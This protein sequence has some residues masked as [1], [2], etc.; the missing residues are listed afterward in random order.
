M[1]LEK[2]EKYAIKN[3]LGD[4]RSNW[5]SINDVA[6]AVNDV[7]GGEASAPKEPFQER[8]RS[9]D[10]NHARDEYDKHFENGNLWDTTSAVDSYGKAFQR[11]T[12][13]GRR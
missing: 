6:G 2:I 8:E 4:A 1:A 9:D 12:A 7:L 5:N 3:G 11:A 13:A 10:H